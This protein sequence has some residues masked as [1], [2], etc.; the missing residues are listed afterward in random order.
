M[1]LT[2]KVTSLEL[3]KKLHEAGITKDMKCEFWWKTGGKLG[4]K[5]Y[6]TLM[7]KEKADYDMHHM[8]GTADSAWRFFPAPLSVELGEVLPSGVVRRKE[9]GD[10]VDSLITFWKLDYK[11]CARVGEFGGEIVSLAFDGDSDV[12]VKAKILLYLHKENLL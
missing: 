9:N 12:D 4:G 7:T 11:Y 2:D 6:N 3:S 10:K 8:F 5:R 1:R